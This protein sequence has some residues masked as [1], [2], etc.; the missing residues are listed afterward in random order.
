LG[1]LAW[2]YWRFGAPVDNGYGEQ[3]AFSTPLLLG[4]YGQL[5][6]TGEG[7]FFYNPILIASLFGWPLFLREHA[8]AGW[9]ALVMIAAALVLYGKIWCWGGDSS[10]GPRY[11]LSVLPFAFIAFAWVPLP[12]STAGK[13]SLTALVLISLWVQWIGV[14]VPISIDYRYKDSSPW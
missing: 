1:S 13:I 3:L 12:T 10:W 9:T 6:S 4:L 11:L 14:T 5:L 7:V 8:Q 2:N